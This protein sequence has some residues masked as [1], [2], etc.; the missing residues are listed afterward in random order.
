MRCGCNAA[1]LIKLGCIKRASLIYSNTF[2][3]V[4]HVYIT[5]LSGLNQLTS[6]GADLL[7]CRAGSRNAA[8][9]KMKLYATVGNCE[10]L[11]TSITKCSILV[12][13]G[14][15]DLSDN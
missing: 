1:N 3:E 2:P 9:F 12:M 6:F 14:F 13:T 8:T 11:L 4:M 5:I 15:I 7:Q 10:T